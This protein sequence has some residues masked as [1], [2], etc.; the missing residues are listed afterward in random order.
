MCFVTGL[1]ETSRRPTGQIY[2]AGWRRRGCFVACTDRLAYDERG[3]Y[4][5]RLAYN[6]SNGSRASN[7]LCEPDFQG[8]TVS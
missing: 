4:K 6:Y 8:A 2:R 1:S 3:F 7:L 5:G